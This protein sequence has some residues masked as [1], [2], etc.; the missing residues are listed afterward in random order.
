MNFFKSAKIYAEMV[1]LGHTLFALPFALSALCLAH[2]AGFGFGAGKIFW[3]VVAFAAARSA[4]MGFNRIA[5]RKFDILN[6]R[7]ANRP[8]ATGEISVRDAAVFTAFSVAVFSLSAA[9]LNRLCFWLSFPALVVLLGYSY[10]KRFTCAAHYILGAALALAPIGAWIAAADSLDPRILALGFALFF[11]ISAFD[12][13]YA[14]QDEK[15]DIAHNLHSVPARFGRKNTLR[16]ASVSFAAAAAC[17]AATGVLFGLNWVYY[18]CVA[19]IAAMYAYG[20]YAIT[21]FGESKTQLVFFYESVSI[22]A[23]IFAGTLSNMIFR[24]G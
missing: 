21:K 24:H 23:L 3:T 19:A 9:M 18:A 8:T 11:N 1:K 10:A 15:F 2:L 14:L 22:S 17:L 12:L 13:I 5:D 16:I 20:I 7:T 4:A 6:P